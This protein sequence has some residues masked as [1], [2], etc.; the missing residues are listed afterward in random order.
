VHATEKP[1]IT[2]A[3]VTTEPVG[4]FVVELESV[5]LGTTSCVICEERAL[6]RIALPHEPP[7]RSRDAAH[8]GRRVGVVQVLSR[9]VRLGEAPGFEPLELLTHRRVD[10]RSE[11]A[12]GRERG[13]PLQ[14]VAKLTARGETNDLWGAIV[15][16]ESVTRKSVLGSSVE[17]FCTP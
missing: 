6:T 8:P 13:E 7:H 5:A 12:P 2:G 14:L 11:V 9:L 16:G 3:S 4:L 15:Y 1:D 17:G 10:D